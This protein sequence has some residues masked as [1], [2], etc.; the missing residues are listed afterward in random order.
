MAAILTKRVV[1]ILD[2]EV[3]EDTERHILIRP[4]AVISFINSDK[5]DSITFTTL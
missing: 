2:D 4:D 5:L 3:I 1:V